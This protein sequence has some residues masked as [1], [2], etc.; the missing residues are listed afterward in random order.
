L[1]R[2]EVRLV[3]L[4]GPAGVGKTRLGLQA[5]A[6]LSEQFCDGIFFV[7]LAPVTELPQVVPTIMQTLSIREQ[8]ASTPLDRLASA[9]EDKQLLLLLDTF[10]QVAEAALQVAA[11]LSTCPRLKVLATSRVRLHLQAEREFAVSPLSVPSFTSF[12]DATSLSQYE[13]ARLFVARA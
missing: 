11:L 13:A 6:E 10:E 4:T 8:G 7:S 12:P 2:E 5:G 9:L 3:T 1:L